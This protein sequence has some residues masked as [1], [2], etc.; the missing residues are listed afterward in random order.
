MGYL[1]SGHSHHID[2]VAINTTMA[3]SIF[4]SL[5]SFSLLLSSLAS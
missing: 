4:S 5:S 2:C 1:L 3:V